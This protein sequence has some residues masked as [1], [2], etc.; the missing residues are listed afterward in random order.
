MG[1]FN[2]SKEAKD[3]AEKAAIAAGKAVADHPNDQAQALPEAITI[4][5]KGETT[6]GKV[7]LKP[8]VQGMVATAKA[9]VSNLP[10]FAE[11]AV[12][13]GAEHVENSS[14]AVG[15]FAI[16]AILG[17]VFI[18]GKKAYAA[19]FEVSPYMKKLQ[20]IR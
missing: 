5:K 12:A 1:G 8:R 11:G 15:A 17:G 7:D 10:Q 20:F 14:Q 6:S 13:H 9:A 18:I 3:N 19:H 2:L 16:M 4:V